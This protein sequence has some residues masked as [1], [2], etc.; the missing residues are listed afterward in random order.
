MN[1]KKSVLDNIFDGCPYP[2]ISI[3][4]DYLTFILPVI[5]FSLLTLKE[6]FIGKMRKLYKVD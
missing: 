1:I 5:S 3:Y 2:C 4:S 6:C